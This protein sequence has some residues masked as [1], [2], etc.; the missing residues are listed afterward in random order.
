MFALAFGRVFAYV[1]IS[2]FGW[3]L[4][5]VLDLL[6]LLR[7]VLRKF[8]GDAGERRALEMVIDLYLTCEV[9]IGC[10]L[11]CWVCWAFCG[12]VPRGCN[13]TG[14]TG[15]LSVIVNLFCCVRF[16]LQYRKIT[17]NDKFK[18][19]DCGENTKNE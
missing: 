17:V 16:L 14:K 12:L 5:C 13:N 1:F 18:I 19:V 6:G 9:L 7:G 4:G 2:V 8:C 3:V 15:A 11:V 10:L